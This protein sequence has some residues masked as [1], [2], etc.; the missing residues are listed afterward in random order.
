MAIINMEQIIKYCGF[1]AFQLAKNNQHNLKICLR[2]QEKNVI[3]ALILEDFFV[4]NYVQIFVQSNQIVNSVCTC[5]KNL[6]GP[7]EHIA[8]LLFLSK[9][10]QFGKKVSNIKEILNSKLFL[11]KLNELSI[12]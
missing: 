1:R 2:R 5:N 12:S 3:S 8:I 10:N 11:F 4:T 7:C 9:E 6:L